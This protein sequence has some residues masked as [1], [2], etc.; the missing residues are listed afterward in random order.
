MKAI[1]LQ[2]RLKAMPLTPSSFRYKKAVGVEIECFS[3][4]SIPEN[5]L[6][7]WV[8][9]D[10][11]NSVCP[12]D[13]DYMEKEF[14]ILLP[15]NH[16][17]HRLKKFCSILHKYSYEVNNSCGLHVHF[18][19]RYKTH[20]EVFRLAD[21]LDKWLYTL[22]GLVESHRRKSEWCEFGISTW[23]RYRAV[24]F[25]SYKRH[26]TLEIRLL[27]GTTDASKIINWIRL[28]EAIIKINRFPLTTGCLSALKELP[29]QKKDRIYWTKQYKMLN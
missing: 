7:F 6:P 9:E 17:K 23:N 20:D 28:I 15:R 26:E 3:M 29:L 27:E 5:R 24:N 11:D 2:K 18:D 12:P 16:L 13:E 14:K 21:E 22:R 25:L 1:K 4:D 10:Y 8:R 19:M